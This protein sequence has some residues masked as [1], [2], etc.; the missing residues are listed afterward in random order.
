MKV[1][2]LATLSCPTNF[3]VWRDFACA[4]QSISAE[5]EG[6]FN[7][8]EEEACKMGGIT[9]ISSRATVTV[10]SFP[11]RGQNLVDGTSSEWWTT[12]EAA[13]V[14]LDLGRATTV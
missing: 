12:E 6:L 14:E 8:V 13:G 5:S 11:E 10:S 3:L 4:G 2:D 9:E 1:L 7:W